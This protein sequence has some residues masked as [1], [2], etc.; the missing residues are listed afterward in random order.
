MLGFNRRIGETIIIGNNI[1]IK[2][3]RIRGNQIHLVIN[4]PKDIEVHR[5]EIYE[6]IPSEKKSS[7]HLKK[8]I[9]I[10]RD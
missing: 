5:I 7:H 4:A 10:E 8:T 2:A 1:T 6:K 9:Y 3:L